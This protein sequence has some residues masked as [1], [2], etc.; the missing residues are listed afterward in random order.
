M[1]VEKGLIQQMTSLAD[2]DGLG[3]DHELR[4]KAAALSDAIRS[5]QPTAKIVG[6]WAA[7][8]R[9]WCQY[10]EEPLI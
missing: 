5:G 10:T 8:R 1:S 6:A 7:A 4:E 3:R 9:A 2:M